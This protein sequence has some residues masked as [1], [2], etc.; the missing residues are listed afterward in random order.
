[1][2]INPA[3]RWFENSDA[4]PKGFDILG[5]P[6]NGTFA[7]KIVISAEQVEKKPGHLTWKMAAA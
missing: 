5:M 3:L 2:I 6:D 4:P 1:M 7:E